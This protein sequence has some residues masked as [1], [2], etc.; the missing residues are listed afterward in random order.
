MPIREF[1]DRD[2]TPVQPNDLARERKP[3]SRPAESPGHG[4]VALTEP[5][6]DE[7]QLVR[8]DPN[9]RVGDGDVDDVVADI[10]RDAHEPARLRE[11]QC[12]GDD[13]HEDPLELARVDAEPLG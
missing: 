5:L 4:R 3:N 6:E 2:V 12:V 7:A 1:R 13:V 11:L 9:P 10:D 8:P